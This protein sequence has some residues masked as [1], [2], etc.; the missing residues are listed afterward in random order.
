MRTL[1]MYICAAGAQPEAVRRASLWAV[2]NLSLD[3]PTNRR[4]GL[5][6][7]GLGLGLWAVWNLS[8]DQPTNRR[9]LYRTLI[10]ALA[11]TQPYNLSLALTLAL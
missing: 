11:L 4:L 2:W 8:L 3:Q 9:L 5:L 7:L 1:D 6:G 10:S